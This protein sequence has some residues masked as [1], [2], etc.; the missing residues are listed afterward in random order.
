MPLMYVAAPF[1]GAV[2]ASQGAAALSQEPLQ[3][4]IK[5]ANRQTFLQNIYFFHAFNCTS[6]AL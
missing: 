1:T 6:V 3:R 4:Y 5:K 2:F